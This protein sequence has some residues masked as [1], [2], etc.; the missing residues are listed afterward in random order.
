MAPL[1]VAHPSTIGNT[2]TAWEPR[3]ESLDR[4]EA[5]QCTSAKIRLDRDWVLS[6]SKAQREHILAT[7]QPYDDG[8]HGDEAPFVL[9]PLG[10]RQLKTLIEMLFHAPPDAISPLRF[11]KNR[12]R[13]DAKRRPRIH[14]PR[15]VVSPPPRYPSP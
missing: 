15:R 11:K 8:T 4:Q 1:R 3:L 13:V 7:A 2:M 10:D 5:W 6:L 12:R 14:V 9:P